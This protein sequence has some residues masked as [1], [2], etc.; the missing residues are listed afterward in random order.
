MS[1]FRSPW[2]DFVFWVLNSNLLR[3]VMAEF[4]TSTINQLTQ[5]DLNNLVIPVPPRAEQIEIDK[6]LGARSIGFEHAVS[7][8][9]RQIELLREY[10]TRLIADIVTG[11]LDVRE[12]VTRLPDEAPLDATEDDAEVDDEIE[13]DDQEAIA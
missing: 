1:I 8:L 2:N 3:F 7:R 11:K 9:E 13:A 12:A 6:F 10:R 4:E 5:R